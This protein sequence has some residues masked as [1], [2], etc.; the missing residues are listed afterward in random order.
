MPPAALKSALALTLS[1]L[2]AGC[3]TVSVTSKGP[4]LPSPAPK[5][6]LVWST[7]DSTKQGATFGPEFSKSFTNQ[8]VVDLRGCG[9]EARV[10]AE[11][12]LELDGEGIEK[13]V[14]AAEADAVLTVR[15]SKGYLGEFGLASAD[16]AFTLLV[17][18]DEKVPMAETVRK[19]GKVKTA[20]EG[21]A[22]FFKGGWLAPPLSHQA[23][24]FAN[25][26]VNKAI[27][28]GRFPGCA[29]IGPPKT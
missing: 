13:A 26:V 8:L 2:A 6:L 25:E 16:F 10:F 4:G 22:H 27:A 9:V 12:G 11:T 20:W 23:V 14:V 18:A 28:D 7:L 17:S 3:G 5:R 15:K 1:L 24:G 19:N 21:D 29:P